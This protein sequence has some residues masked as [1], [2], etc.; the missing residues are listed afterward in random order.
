MI[1]TRNGVLAT[2]EE[3]GDAR[4]ADAY[5]VDDMLILRTTAQ[6]IGPGCGHGGARVRVHRIHHWFDERRDYGVMIVKAG[7]WEG[8]L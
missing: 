2:L 7:D 4:I 6:P 1:C 5:V 8:Q 3:Y